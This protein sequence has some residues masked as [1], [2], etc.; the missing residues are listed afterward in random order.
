M[1][2]AVDSALFLRRCTARRADGYWQWDDARL[3]GKGL[4]RGIVS[5]PRHG[6]QRCRPRVAFRRGIG[7]DHCGALH[8]P[9]GPTCPIRRSLPRPT[10]TLHADT[11]P[12]ATRLKV[13]AAWVV[14]LVGA[15]SIGIYG[16][17]NLFMA[18]GLTATLIVT[19]IAFLDAGRSDFFANYGWVPY[20]WLA[21]ALASELRFSSRS[22]LDTSISL[23]PWENFAEAGIYAMVGALTIRSRHVLV[24]ADPRRIRKQPLVLWPPLALASTLWSLVP[25]FSF[26]RAL[27]LLIPIGLAL[28]MVRIWLSSPSFGADL[29]RRTFRVF[30]SAVTVLVLI[31]FLSG[32]WRVARFTWPGMHTTAAAV[33]IGVCFIILVAAGRSYLRLGMSGYVFRL[34]LFAVALYLCESRTVVAAVLLALGIV[35]WWTARTKPL[36][37]YLGV[38]YYVLS[39]GLLLL[40]ALQFLVRYALRGGTEEGLTSLSDRIPLWTAAVHALSDA[41]RW[42]V[43]FGYGSGRVILPTEFSWAG[44]AHSSWVELLFGIGILGPLLL[45]VDVFFMIRHGASRRSLVPPALSLGVIA[46]LVAGSITG[47]TLA[48]PGLGLAM[49]S[50]LHV[51]VFVRLSTTRVQPSE[52]GAAAR[53]ASTRSDG[54]GHPTLLRPTSSPP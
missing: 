33:Y 23:A 52:P 44:N 37:S 30:V 13:A 49:M 36:K 17:R 43:G 50:L 26:V 51:P 47:E 9:D 45:A 15:A 11:R 39:V 24:T 20:A 10:V 38:T 8:P 54:N 32:A 4:L 16:Q 5:D 31:G 48:F 40:T 7:R 29:W 27:E 28:L 42:L 1:C 34:V 12:I 19:S 22:P 2:C 6:Y 25:L 21:L 14:V 35:F 41:N 46:V 53:L 18:A 3:F